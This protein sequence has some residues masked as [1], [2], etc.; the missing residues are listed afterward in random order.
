MFINEASLLPVLLPDLK[1]VN[2]LLLKAQNWLNKVA[3]P[4]VANAPLKELRT[5]LH[6]G[7]QRASFLGLQTFG[8]ASRAEVEAVLMRLARCNDVK[9]RGQRVPRLRLEVRF[10]CSGRLGLWASQKWMTRSPGVRAHIRVPIS[11][12]LAVSL[13]IGAGK[14]RV[15]AQSPRLTACLLRGL[16]GAGCTHCCGHV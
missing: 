3:L 15:Q 4:S 14:T 10:L 8:G 16:V 11:R 1:S 9:A 12:S 7:K 6:A 13:G 5:L 2:D